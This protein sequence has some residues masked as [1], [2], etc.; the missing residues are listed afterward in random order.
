MAGLGE[1]PEELPPCVGVGSAVEEAPPPTMTTG[2]E[3]DNEPPM[4]VFV[5]TAV[6]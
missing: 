4:S 3:L 1:D 2:A 5:T 6:T